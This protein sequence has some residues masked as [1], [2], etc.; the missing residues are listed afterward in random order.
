MVVWAAAWPGACLLDRVAKMSYNLPSGA[1]G[2]L[3]SII[4]TDINGKVQ[5]IKNKTILQ[6]GGHQQGEGG[7]T[8]AT[9]V[10]D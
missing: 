2:V 5:K 6:Q 9:V 10:V 3:T 4:G 1:L 7:S 8:I